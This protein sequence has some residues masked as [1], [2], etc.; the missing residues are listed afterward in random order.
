MSRKRNLARTS[1]FIRADQLEQLRLIS[2]QTGA[3]IAFMV[4]QGIDHYLDGHR[5][6][7]VK[8]NGGEVT[9]ERS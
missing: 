9:S 3:A 7:S 6:P 5:L 4:R 2:A 8:D 1:L